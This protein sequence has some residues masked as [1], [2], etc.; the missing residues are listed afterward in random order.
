MKSNQLHQDVK[1]ILQ[2][3]RYLSKTKYSLGGNIRDIESINIIDPSKVLQAHVTGI[4]ADEKKFIS[5]LTTDIYNNFYCLDNTPFDLS[6]AC[7]I[8]DFI[9]ELSQANSGAGTWEDGWLLVGEDDKQDKLIVQKRK[10]NFWVSKENFIPLLGLSGMVK[11]EKEIRF[12]N[13]HFYYAFGNTNKR[14]VKNYQNQQLR[15]YW[16]LTAKGAI[17]YIKLITKE[18]NKNKIHFSTK[19]IADHS[20]YK[21]TDAGVLYIDYSQVTEA[22]PVIRYVHEKIKKLLKE[23]VPMFVKKIDQGLGFAEDPKNGLSFG[24]SRSKI[25]AETLY[26]CFN[27]EN[28]NELMIELELIKSF[29]KLGI[30]ASQPYASTA[31]LNEYEY[32]FNK[33]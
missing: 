4:D 15:F 19:V 13:T 23:G 20:N 14:E 30:N 33:N 9:M 28:V 10:I 11:I 17:E 12:L 6:A 29:H 27:K 24:I 2:S 21:R 31:K 32:L 1:N 16:N 18:L 7:K 3:F 8:D 22:M 26:D 25:I 5:I